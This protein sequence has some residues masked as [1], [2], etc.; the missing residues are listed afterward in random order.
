MLKLIRYVK[1]YELMLA[2]AIALLFAQAMCDL[3]LPDYMS[4]IVNIG[5][6]GGDTG[7][8]L[9]VGGV[10]LLI[11]LAGGVCAVLVGLIAATTGAG[12]AQHLRSDVFAKVQDFSNT[13][14]DSF[15]TASLITRS[16]ND[17]NQ[18]QKIGR[19]HV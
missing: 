14:F 11:S 8:I 4:N 6:V 17:I 3:A 15:S 2:A 16:T 5:I 13:E 19:A 10:M 18:I 1:P 12:I 9:R 7:Y